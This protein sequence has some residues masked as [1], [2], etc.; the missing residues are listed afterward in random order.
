MEWS[1]TDL[2][3]FTWN[4][5]SY[6]NL[7]KIIHFLYLQ[8]SLDQTILFCIN[9]QDFLF[10]S[11][12]LILDQKVEI[13]AINSVPKFHEIKLFFSQ[14]MAK[15]LKTINW[16]QGVKQCSSSD[17]E[18]IKM[19]EEMDKAILAKKLGWLH[20]VIS[21]RNYDDIW[22]AAHCTWGS[23]SYIGAERSKNLVLDIK[24]AAKQM[25]DIEIMGKY[26]DLLNEMLIMKEDMGVIL[27][28]TLDKTGLEALKE[29]AIKLQASG[30]R[31]ESGVNTN[32]DCAKC[33]IF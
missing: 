26:L 3:M 11:D 19:I 18:F 30:C 28:R 15:I 33:S 16:E 27:N 17:Q 6:S 7:E 13:I 21:N 2:C 20:N 8:M 12:R 5:F 22:M 23:F 32:P 9:I 10:R 31:Y 25:D 24:T 29:A 1:N 14:N 4:Y